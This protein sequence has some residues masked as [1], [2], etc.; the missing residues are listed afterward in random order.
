MHKTESLKATTEEIVRNK[1]A[2]QKRRSAHLIE[3]DIEIYRMHMK[4]ISLR[5]IAH[6]V[7][8]KSQTSVS[9]A[10]QRGKQHVLDRG[11]DLEESRITIHQFFEETLGEA[12]QQMRE[13][14]ASGTIT[15][16]TDEEGNVFK[17]MTKGVD[18]RLLAEIGRSSTRWAEFL[19]LMD[20]APDSAATQQ[21]TVVLSAP[22]A[23]TEFESRYANQQLTP[24]AD[25]QTIDTQAVPVKAQ[26]ISEGGPG[27]DAA[28]A[29]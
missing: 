4:G 21:T 7:G 17:K 27:W 28:A 15:I 26:V 14:R 18:V 6:E 8:L 16:T 25:Q 24:S 9:A 5:S 22:S 2:G 11:I 3:R 1:L 23:G 10:V 12:M 20:R 13:Q 29:D 19:G